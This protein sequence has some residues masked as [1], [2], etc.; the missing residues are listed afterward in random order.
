MPVNFTDPIY[1]IL[2]QSVVT[3]KWSDAPALAPLYF[4]SGR[5][6][7]RAG[8][9]VLVGHLDGGTQNVLL[10]GLLLVFFAV[11]C[12]SPGATA[13]RKRNAPGKLSIGET[14]CLDGAAASS[15]MLVGDG[16]FEP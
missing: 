14:F 10:G 12:N 5:L 3:I 6:R 15:G 13:Q 4:R 8:N 2:G 1:V 11:R 9:A 16:F 7:L